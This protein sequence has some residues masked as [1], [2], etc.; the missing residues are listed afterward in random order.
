MNNI[1]SYSD[2]YRNNQHIGIWKPYDSENIKTCNWG[3]YR[4]P[5][6]GD[7]DIGAGEF[8][9][10]SKKKKTGGIISGHFKLQYLKQE[11]LSHILNPNTIIS[12]T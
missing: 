7:L 9:V 4:I 10:N 3:N 12:S 6:S 1:D 2:S 11:N 5:F 8:S